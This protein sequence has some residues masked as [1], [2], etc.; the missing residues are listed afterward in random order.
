MMAE[1]HRLRRLQ[2]GEAWHDGGGVGER[3]L[4]EHTLVASEQAVDVIDRIAHP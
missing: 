4:R 2:M 3:L 1:C